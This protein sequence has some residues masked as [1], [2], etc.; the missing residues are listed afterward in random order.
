MANRRLGASP[1][2]TDTPAEQSALVLQRGGHYTGPL[3]AGRYQVLGETRAN[4]YVVDH[5][6]TDLLVRVAGPLSDILRFKTRED[7]ERYVQGAVGC[8]IDPPVQQQE[9]DMARRARVT[10]APAEAPKRG[11][12][13]VNGTKT[14]AA[15]E[16]G[17]RQRKPGVG[18]LTKELILKGYD[19]GKVIAELRKK[20]PD[21]ANSVSNVNFYRNKLRKSGELQA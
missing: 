14:A 18:A 7:A 11:R 16:K 1:V 17:G 12:K 21:A 13:A 3:V 5:R 19:N 6:R 8:A 15:P 20:F 4:Y 10:E 2:W 9:S